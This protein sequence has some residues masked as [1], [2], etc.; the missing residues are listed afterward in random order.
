MSTRS[1]C[2]RR[3]ASWCASPDGLIS[4][5]FLGFSTPPPFYTAPAHSALL[6]EKEGVERE[7]LAWGAWVLKMY[8]PCPWCGRRKRGIVDE[9]Y[10]SSLHPPCPDTPPRAVLITR[11]PTS[12]TGAE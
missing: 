9:V 5:N 2:E 1:A 3:C 4:L 7:R 8:L 10:L 11:G 6:I 12:P